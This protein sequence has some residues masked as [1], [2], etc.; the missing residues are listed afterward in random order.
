[1]QR[2]FLLLFI[3]I[4]RIVFCQSTLPQFIDTNLYKQEIIVQG[5]TDIYSSSLENIFINKLL[6][7]GEITSNEIQQQ[8]ISQR[9]NNSIAAEGNAELEYRNYALFPKKKWG[10]LLKSSVNTINSLRYTKDLFGL[11]FAGNGAFLGKP[12]Q[13][14]PS[15]IQSISYLKFGI[16]FIHKTTKSNFSLNVFKIENYISSTIDYGAL[17]VNDSSNLTLLDITGTSTSYFPSSKRSNFGVGI[18]FDLKIPITTFTDKI[19]Q[20]NL[21]AKNFGLGIL[22]ND[23][24]F[25]SVDTNYI[26]QGLSI[27]QLSP[28]V[29]GKQTSQKTLQDLTIYSSN[30]IRFT[31][32]LGYIQVEKMNSMESKSRFQSIFGVRM[33]PSLSYIP[34]LYGGIQVRCTDKIWLGIHENYGITNTLRTGIYLKINTPS[35]GF[36]L[37]TENLLDTFRSTGKGHSFQCK[38]QWHI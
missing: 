1:M 17:Y 22:S 19:I 36:C 7:G 37:G 34:Y 13:I 32:L 6:F 16:G 14:N 21:I 38:L 8:H 25:Y 5:K 4:S 26:F 31:P 24:H 27:D 33:Y 35:L 10:L 11:L 9:I 29:S 20:I 23:V 15:S 2:I 18:D 3:S 30:K 12:L 28:I